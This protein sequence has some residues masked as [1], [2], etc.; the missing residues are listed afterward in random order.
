M[1]SMLCHSEVGDLNRVH[2]KHVLKLALGS[3]ANRSGRSPSCFSSADSKFLSPAV[4][5]LCKTVDEARRG[6]S[7]EPNVTTSFSVHSS[8]V[9]FH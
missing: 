1:C 7:Y 8:P 3:A 2:G 4:K 5:P 9:H 6:R